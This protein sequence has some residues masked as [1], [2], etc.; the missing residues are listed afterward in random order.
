MVVI[1]FHC[2]L[3]LKQDLEDR[4]KKLGWKRNFMIREAIKQYLGETGRGK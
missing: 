3:A 2:D 4:A 1:S